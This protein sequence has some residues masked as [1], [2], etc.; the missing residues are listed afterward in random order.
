MR[1]DAACKAGQGGVGSL[2]RR[3]RIL[4]QRQ[5]VHHVRARDDVNTGRGAL[6]ALDRIF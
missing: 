6:E 4:S 3:N 1:L 2:H 5:S